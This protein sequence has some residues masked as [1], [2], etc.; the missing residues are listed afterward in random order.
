MLVTHALETYRPTRKLC[1]IVKVKKVKADIA[2]HGNPIS[3]LRPTGRHLPYGITQCYLPPDTSERAPPNPSHAGWYSICLPRKD[4]RLSWPSWLDSAPILSQTCD[5]SITCQT[6]NR[7]STKTNQAKFWSKLCKFLGNK[8]SVEYSH[9]VFGARNLCEK[10]K[11]KIRMYYRSGTGERCCVAPG[12]QYVCIHQVSAPFYVKWR[13]MA[14]I[15]KVWRQMENT[16][17]QIDAYLL[18]EQPGQTL[19]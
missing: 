19:A 8:L 18:Q 5:L 17:P 10:K 15:L 14:A 13:V 6:P 3:E 11:Q 2:L 1:D 16:T 9:I 12:I 4:G 7:R